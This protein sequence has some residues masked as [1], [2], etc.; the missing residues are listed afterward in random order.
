M[1]Q[2]SAVPGEESP[3]R[4]NR[5]G[6][7]LAKSSLVLGEQKRLPP[8]E[9]GNVTF[10]RT[11]LWRVL[12]EPYIP[13]YQGPLAMPTEVENVERIL[14]TCGR[15]LQMGAFCFRSK[16][17]AGLHLADEPNRPK[18]G[19]YVLYEKYAGQEVHL[20]APDGG[21]RILR[22]LNDTEILMVVDD[23]EAIKGYL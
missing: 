23:P 21:E 22:L 19:D 1:T 2:T 13:K 7:A 6:S 20:R 3:Q 11:I 10:G 16:T 17:A 5:I 15:I 4:E 9:P 18:V 8:L 12:V 14:A